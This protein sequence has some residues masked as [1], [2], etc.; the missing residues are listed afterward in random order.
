MTLVNELTRL[1]EDLGHP[2]PSER[3]AAAEALGRAGESAIDPLIRALRDENPGV[4]DAAIRS[5]I[6]VGGEATA[7][8]L[9]PL[10][11]E[12]SYFR[13]IGLVIF[14][15]IGPAAV[16]PLCGLLEDDRDDI[17]AFGVNLIGEIG[18]CDCSGPIITLLASDPGPNVRTAAARCLGILRDRAAVPALIR[19]LQDEEWVCFAAIESLAAIGDDRAVE[20]VGALLESASPAVRY[21]AIEAIGRI[22]STR[23]SGLLLA[24][25]PK[26]EGMEKTAIVKSLVQIGVTPSMEGMAETLIQV[27]VRGAWD[28]KLVALR[29]LVDLGEKHAIPLVIDVA[30]SLD[31]SDPASEDRLRG[32]M[33]AISLFGCTSLLIDVLT[34]PTIK[35]RGKVF[36]IRVLAE[37][38]CTE[39]LPRLISLLE[40]GHVPVVLAAV[41]AVSQIAGRNAADLLAPLRVHGDRNVREAVCRRLERA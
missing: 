20:A 8:K 3:R 19:A 38:G 37:M 2:D 34:D 22:G 21:A 24:R 5:L 11:Y 7:S 27:F 15:E 41:D 39:A 23:A 25:L 26:A 1:I 6:A 10:L 4:Q 9:L 40:G 35:Y 31:P 16:A 33:Q 29:G 32:I 14:K 13:S 17:R 12:G 36:A 30:G 28:E 18:T